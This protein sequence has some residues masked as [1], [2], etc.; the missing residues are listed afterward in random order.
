MK[1]LYVGVCNSQSQVPSAFFW[2]VMSLGSSIP[3]HFFRSIN[4]HG[5]IRNNQLI[6]GFLDSGFE[7]FTK[8]D[9]DQA[10]P[11]NYFKTMVPLIDKYKVV[12]P[13]IFDRWR[14]SN[15]APLAFENI[16]Q[17]K[18]FPIDIK[19]KTGVHPYAYAHTNLFMHREVLESIEPPW[20]DTVYTE[21]RMAVLENCDRYFIR[22]LTDAGYKTYVNFDVV[23]QHI[24]ENGV[25]RKF[26]EHWNR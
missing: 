15:F 13:L 14:T 11:G 1:K 3:A 9:I 5:F 2:T 20:F 24:T 8:M 26:Y 25:D 17:D 4:K 7:Y 21:D 6:K 10:Y 16:D 19:G 18:A 23:V 22:K 12:A